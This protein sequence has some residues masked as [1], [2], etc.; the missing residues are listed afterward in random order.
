MA[1]EEQEFVVDKAVLRA[2]LEQENKGDADLQDVLDAF[3]LFFQGH[4]EQMIS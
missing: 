2:K 4:C 3:D 1:G